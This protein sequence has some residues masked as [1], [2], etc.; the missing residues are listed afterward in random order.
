MH[1]NFNKDCVIELDRLVL[2]SAKAGSSVNPQALCE[3]A[4]QLLSIIPHLAL[5]H[6]AY[7][8]GVDLG[9][10]EV[11]EQEQFRAFLK[12]LHFTAQTNFGA[13]H[14][15]DSALWTAAVSVGFD[16]SGKVCSPSDF[17]VFAKALK[18]PNPIL[19]GLSDEELLLELKR[20]KIKISC[21]S[22]N[23]A[24]LLC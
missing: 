11:F 8:C 10:K 2:A 15:F 19:V 14:G 24:L 20:R 9:T 1:T 23:F 12:A 18:L 6:R 21:S 22:E 13:H 4:L 16:L 17:A 7:F 3:D 5:P